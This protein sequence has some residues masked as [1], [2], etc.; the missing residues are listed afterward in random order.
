MDTQGILDNDSDSK[1]IGFIFSLSMAMSNLTLYNCMSKISDDV[2]N[3]LATFAR[4][5]KRMT[6]CKTFKPI[7][8]IVRDWA[9]AHEYPFGEIGGNALLEKELKVT[10][11]TNQV[12]VDMKNAI[13]LMFPIRSCFLLPHPGMKVFN[14][15][16]PLQLSMLED[17]FF[18]YVDMLC[19]ELFIAKVIN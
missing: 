3:Q 13:K 9:N 19:R 10:K 16:F 2:L 18:T 8:F 14:G 15:A 12:T 6:K 11:K 17:D 7:K 5:V 4:N 1:H